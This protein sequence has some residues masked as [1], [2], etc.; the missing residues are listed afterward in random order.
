MDDRDLG[1]AESGIFY[2]NF[3]FGPI[4]FPARDSNLRQFFSTDSPQTP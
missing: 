3:W 2:A 4:Q 1:N